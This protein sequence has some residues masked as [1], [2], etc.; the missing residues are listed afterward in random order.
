MG[1]SKGA[2]PR[3]LEFTTIDTINPEITN[4]PESE[5]WWISLLIASSIVL[6]AVIARIEQGS[7]FA[8]GA[9]F[10]LT[11]SAYSIFPLLLASDV[12]IQPVGVLAIAIAS[13]AVYAGSMLGV[14]G[15]HVRIPVKEERSVLG[16]SRSRNPIGLARWPWLPHVT[17]L[18]TVSGI[19]AIGV[20]TLS[21]GY[22]FHDLLSPE[23]LVAMSARFSILRYQEGYTPPL[24][25]QGLTLGMYAGALFGGALFAVS[26][27]RIHKALATLPL[28]PAVAFTLILTT[29]ASFLFQIILWCASLFAMNI[30]VKGG[31]C[32]LF[33]KKLVRHA[34]WI[35]PVLGGL[36]SSALFLRYGESWDS[37]ESLIWPRLRVDLIGHLV[38]F[39]QWMGGEVGWNVNPSWGVYTFAGLF[40]WFGW[41]ARIQGVYDEFVEIGS[42]LSL[43]STNI[44]TV[45]RG[46]IE[47]FTMPGALVILFCTG[48][49][50]GKAYRTIHTGRPSALAI[51]TAFYGF[52]LCSHIVSIATYNT[53]L[54][55]LTVFGLA[56]CALDHQQLW[57]GSASRLRPH[58]LGC[59]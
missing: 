56:L 48:F 21:E 24:L 12:I 36:M 29:R 58:G 7:W 11:W 45:F 22:S 49:V 43:S 50:A 16:N 28:L 38:A 20:I 25:A 26:V 33:S 39:S 19:L 5:Y 15:V 4:M 42:G 6:T 23:S 13:F 3:F 37:W 18:G 51:L 41:R 30:Y 14:G 32:S 57:G 53:L 52:T 35:G 1:W 9:F 17:V 46:L 8:P 40:E 47:D 10:L 34:L 44:Y 31:R 2:L 54:G 27:S 59:Q 55:S